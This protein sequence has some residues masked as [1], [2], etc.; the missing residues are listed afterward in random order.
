MGHNSYPTPTLLF[1]QAV[2]SYPVPT[3]SCQF[4]TFQT[5]NELFSRF[6]Q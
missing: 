4:L 2:P 5:F 6:P 1:S 3:P